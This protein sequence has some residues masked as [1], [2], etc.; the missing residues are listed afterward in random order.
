M[1]QGFKKYY[2]KQ[3]NKIEYDKDVFDDIIQIAGEIYSENQLIPSETLSNMACDL[4]IRN[5]MEYLKNYIDSFYPYI[6]ETVLEKYP[7]KNINTDIQKEEE[8]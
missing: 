5:K 6:K 1:N 3:N 7:V 4:Y 8:K 2:N